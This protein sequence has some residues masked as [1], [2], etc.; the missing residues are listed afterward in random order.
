MDS[1]PFSIYYLIQNR[2]SAKTSI[3]YRV[4]IWNMKN[5]M[6]RVFRKVRV[7]F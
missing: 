7:L 2:F 3:K 1:R 5:Y 6:Y 4:D